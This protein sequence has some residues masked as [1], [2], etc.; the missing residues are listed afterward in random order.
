MRKKNKLFVIGIVLV[1]L[2]VF[3]ISGIYSSMKANLLIDEDISKD[4]FSVQLVSKSDKSMH[5]RI[6]YPEKVSIYNMPEYLSVI[7]L[8]RGEE[9]APSQPYGKTSENDFF[10][11]IPPRNITR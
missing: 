1:I 11:R 10:F 3:L 6:M 5:I 9:I 4:S 7:N 8:K 2:M